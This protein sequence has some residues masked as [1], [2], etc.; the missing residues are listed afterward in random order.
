MEQNELDKGKSK[1]KHLDRKPNSVF[2]Q[3]P[4]P[5]WLQE[6]ERWDRSQP[7][8]LKNSNVIGKWRAEFLKEYQ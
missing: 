3:K 8:Q 7:K 2:V 1:Q 5:K 6:V 4:I